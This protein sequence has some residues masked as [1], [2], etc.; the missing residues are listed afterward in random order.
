MLTITNAVIDKDCITF[1]IPENMESGTVI[2]TFKYA[3]M[4]DVR[5]QLFASGADAK[6]FHFEGAKLVFTGAPVAGSAPANTDLYDIH[7]FVR[8]L[9]SGTDKPLFSRVFSTQFSFEA[10]D[11]AQQQIIAAQDA[12]AAAIDIDKA[13]LA[14]QASKAEKTN[15]NKE[16]VQ[17]VSLNSDI[18]YR[19]LPINTGRF[20]AAQTYLW[21]ATVD[22]QGGQIIYTKTALLNRDMF[23]SEKDESASEADSTSKTGI[24]TQKAQPDS[25][26][27]TD[28]TA[29]ITY[30]VSTESPLI[31]IPQT[32]RAEANQDSIQTDELADQYI[33]IW[34]KTDE[35]NLFEITGSFRAYEDD[36]ARN[37]TGRIRLI[38]QD[39]GEYLLVVN[40][41]LIVADDTTIP[42]AYGS[43]QVNRD[44]TWE[45][46]L[47][48]DKPAVEALNGETGE[49]GNIL[50]DFIHVTYADLEGNVQRS[51]E[52]AF[53]INIK[54]RTDSYGTEG[55]DT[56][57]GR[58]GADGL[59]GRGGDDTLEG[60]AGSDVLDGGTGLDILRGG[61]ILVVTNTGNDIFV[62]NLQETPDSSLA[63][64][65]DFM[66]GEDKIRIDTPTGNEKTLEE[67]KTSINIY[68]Q[69]EHIK[70]PSTTNDPN[71]EDTVIYDS[72]GTQDTAD[73]II[74][75]VLEDLIEPLTIGDF[76][77][78]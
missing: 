18:A 30:T 43:L 41:V 72:R 32:M 17:P 24:G 45:Y 46:R 73:D 37:P 68:W 77:I 58:S 61:S 20:A 16:K 1:T 49:V 9:E 3:H 47:D 63:I 36:P 4:A 11:V 7:I 5:L 67:L 57:V 42:T 12:T 54:G 21:I 64:V 34:V 25:V 22:T 27:Q 74:L 53:T 33:P 52:T 71:I 19:V 48:N 23:A 75:M 51:V 35:Q 6:Q 15:A 55:R 29:S 31:Y 59:Y 39:Q 65:T 14:A 26:T 50:T 69:T 40:N 2:A 38:N 44:G 28:T 56:L 13:T 8:V 62:L 66:P 78:V 76:D 70:T 60:G 10:D